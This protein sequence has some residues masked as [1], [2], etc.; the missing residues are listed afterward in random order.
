M[1]TT[2]YAFIVGKSN[3]KTETKELKIELGIDRRRSFN[4]IMEHKSK[5]KE[6]QDKYD[7][8]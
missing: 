3:P 7:K 6:C 4:R 5:I 1:T 2:S 8:W